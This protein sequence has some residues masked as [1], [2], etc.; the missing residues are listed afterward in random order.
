M[1]LTPRDAKDGETFRCPVCWKNCSAG[2][3]GCVS[4]MQF[5]GHTGRIVVPEEG[6]EEKITEEGKTPGLWEKQEP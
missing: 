1:S 3:Q 2:H 5:D 4:T 6:A